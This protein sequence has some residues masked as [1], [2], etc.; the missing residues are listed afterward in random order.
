[1]S[2]NTNSNNKI[3]II[4]PIFKDIKKNNLIQINQIQ[5]L[6]ILDMR[7]EGVSYNAIAKRLFAEH[8]INITPQRVG[9][10]IKKYGE[11][12]RRAQT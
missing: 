6:L 8:N 9:Q 5:T 2:N 11:V 4:H 12:Y 10:V 7:T 3:E 1:M